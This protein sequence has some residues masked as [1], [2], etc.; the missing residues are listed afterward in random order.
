MTNTFT[1]EYGLQTARALKKS[2]KILPVEHVYLFG[3]FARNEAHEDSDIDI[4]VVCRPFDQS[5]IREIRV[6]YS[7]LPSL[8]TRVSLVVLHPNELTELTAVIPNAI[9]TEGIL[10]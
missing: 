10:V 2:W 4:A 6:L 3:S 7:T 1:Q 9:S 8:D 5:K